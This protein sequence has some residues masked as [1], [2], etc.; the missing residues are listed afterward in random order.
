ML[1]NTAHGHTNLYRPNAELPGGHRSVSFQ[2]EGRTVGPVH[3][4]IGENL[5]A[6]LPYNRTSLLNRRPG[7]QRRI[8]SSATLDAAPHRGFASWFVFH[9]L[10]LPPTFL[11][12]VLKLY[13]TPCSDALPIRI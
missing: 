10:E 12:R 5:P 9:A 4:S 11:S 13:G 1:N 6:H 8:F 7:I 2:Y 3:G